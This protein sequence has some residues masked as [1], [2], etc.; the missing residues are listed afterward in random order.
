MT[1]QRYGLSF[2]ASPSSLTSTE[3]LAMIILRRS[4]LTLL[5]FASSNTVDS[6]KASVG[7]SPSS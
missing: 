1:P 4:P 3:V 5:Y 6:L 2:Q 7:E